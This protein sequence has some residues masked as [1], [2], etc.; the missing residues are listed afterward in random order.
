MRYNTIKITPSGNEWKVEC[1]FDAT[2]RVDVDR[3]PSSLGFYHC[4]ETKEA[5]KGFD[6]LKA[7]MID[8]HKHEIRN[9]QKSLRALK[10]TR[11]PRIAYCG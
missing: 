5:S 4:P 10:E 6:E 3:G 11:F 7:Y 1:V 2:E 8:K 9:L